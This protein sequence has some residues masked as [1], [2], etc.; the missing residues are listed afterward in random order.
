MPHKVGLKFEVHRNVTL[1]QYRHK[2]CRNLSG[3]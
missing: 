2:C 3:V 1:C